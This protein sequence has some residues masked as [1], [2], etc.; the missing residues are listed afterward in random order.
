[1]KGEK[2]FFVCLFHIKSLE[3]ASGEQNAKKRRRGATRAQEEKKGTL[4]GNRYTDDMQICRWHHLN[5]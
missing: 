3:E 4:Y 2:A 1:M 5:P